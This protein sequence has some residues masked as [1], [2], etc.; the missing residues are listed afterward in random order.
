MSGF[1]L[2]MLKVFEMKSLYC[3]V[4]GSSKYFRFGKVNFMAR[5]LKEMASNVWVFT[6]LEAGISLNAIKLNIKYVT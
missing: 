4:P 1:S 3:L 6:F 2:S 5:N